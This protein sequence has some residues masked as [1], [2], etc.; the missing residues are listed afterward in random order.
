MQYVVD[1]HVTWG[2]MLYI[3]LTV[4]DNFQYTPLIAMGLFVMRDW[5]V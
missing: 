1:M 5:D 4:G 2:V 3:V